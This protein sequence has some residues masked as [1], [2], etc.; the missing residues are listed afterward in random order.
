MKNKNYLFKRD[1]ICVGTL[2]L[3]KN[4]IKDA[5]GN[6]LISDYSVIRS[7][8]FTINSKGNAK[9][10]LNET[11]SYP[12]LNVENNKKVNK[13]QLIVINQ[14]NIS[15]LLECLG[16]SKELSLKD[17]LKIHKDIF[18][19][20]FGLNYFEMLGVSKYNLGSYRIYLNGKEIIDKDEKYQRFMEGILLNNKNL[21][22]I[23]LL[24]EELIYSIDN[25]GSISFKKVP[26][27][28]VKNLIFSIVK[29]KK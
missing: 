27:E 22:D 14:K 25:Y 16:Y 21:K 18:T 9:D 2:V 10:L 1:D 24:S 26:F 23:D 4:V 8:L 20:N 19:G 6:F 11:F 3:V 15:K 5:K 7:I 12:I 13:F 29:R 28:P 17:I